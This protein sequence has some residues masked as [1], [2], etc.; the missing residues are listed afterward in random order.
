[1]FLP[2]KQVLSA[3]WSNVLFYKKCVVDPRA[4]STSVNNGWGCER[5][6]EAS[7]GGCTHARSA[8]PGWEKLKDKG[9]SLFCTHTYSMH[10]CERVHG[11][12]H[13]YSHFSNTRRVFN[14]FKCDAKAADCERGGDKKM[15]SWVVM[16]NALQ[17]RQQLRKRAKKYSNIM[18]Q[19]FQFPLIEHFKRRRR[20]CL[21]VHVRR[22]WD[23]FLFS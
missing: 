14:L 4:L 10:I 2:V 9:C 6:G 15:P 23:E 7:V 22:R 1:M 17:H 16:Q 12:P 13:W 20:H 3:Q 11:N 21:A 5:K 19:Q 8:P 18:H